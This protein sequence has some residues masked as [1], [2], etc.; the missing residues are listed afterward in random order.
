MKKKVLVLTMLL[1]SACLTGCT[2]EKQ[3]ESEKQ[4][5]ATGFFGSFESVTL[6]GTEVTQD[7]F[8]EADLTMVNIWGTFCGPCISEMP[9]LGEIAEEYAEKGVQIVGIVS[10]VTDP[11]NEEAKAI[12]EQTGADYT[13]IITTKSMLDGYLAGVQVVPTTVFVNSEG[14]KVG[15]IYTGAKTKEVWSGIID[16]LLEEK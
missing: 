15:D 13:H 12:V 5:A 10:D 8:G 6:D 16:E 4:T 9:D 1:I 11:E 2:A 3:P 14:K 7:I